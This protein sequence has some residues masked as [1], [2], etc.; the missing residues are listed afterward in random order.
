MS[1]FKGLLTKN[2]T[3]KLEAFEKA[4]TDLNSVV[5]EINEVILREGDGLAEL[6]LDTVF[7]DM[8]HIILALNIQDKYRGTYSQ[9]IDSYKISSQG[10]PI[11]QGVWLPRQSNPPER[12]S[13]RNTFQ[14]KEDI[15]EH[16]AKFLTEPQSPILI[17]LSFIKR[18]TNEALF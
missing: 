7:E 14:K 10:Y 1:R 8:D 12:F 18:K 17:F 2:L 16:F 3:E 5:S 15:E 13:H 6:K 11:R 9:S 4:K